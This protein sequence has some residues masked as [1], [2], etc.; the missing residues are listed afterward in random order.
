[1]KSIGHTLSWTN[2]QQQRISS[3]LDRR[4]I[5]LLWLS[6]FPD[7][8]THSLEPGLSY[9]AAMLNVK[10]SLKAW[11]RDSFGNAQ[12]KVKEGRRSLDR[13]Q[14]ALHQS[15]LDPTLILQ[16]HEARTKYLQLLA[17]EESF[18]GQNQGKIPS[19]LEIVTPPFSVLLL[20]H[21][22]LTTLYEK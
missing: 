1:M 11:N 4:L 22:K 10:F 14:A 13:F 3:R 21:A 8:Y 12:S 16:E 2:L 20:P 5:N 19:S 7:G 17:E 9:H 6:S 18:I 15:P